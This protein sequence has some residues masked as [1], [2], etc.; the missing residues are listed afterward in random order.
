MDR[1]QLQHF[2]VDRAEAEDTTPVLRLVVEPLIRVI[3]ADRETMTAALLVLPSVGHQ[4]AARG[5]KAVMVLLAELVRE[6]QAF[7]HQLTERQHIALEEALDMEPMEGLTNTPR[8]VVQAVG[9]IAERMALP[10]HREQE[11]EAVLA[12]TAAEMVAVEL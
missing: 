7:N 12:K 11:A 8:R 10:E 6:V 4:V 2:L 9:V 3:A 5:R 1:R